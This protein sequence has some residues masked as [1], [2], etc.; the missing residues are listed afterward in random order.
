MP[1]EIRVNNTADG[2]W[3]ELHTPD[4]Q[5]PLPESRRFGS[6]ADASGGLEELKRHSASRKR[7]RAS[8]SMAGDCYF[9]FLGRDGEPL[10]TSRPFPSFKTLLQAEAHVPVVQHAHVLLG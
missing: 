9:E 5:R 8:H 4:D 3:F 1:A 2:V 10:A 7:Y 6:L